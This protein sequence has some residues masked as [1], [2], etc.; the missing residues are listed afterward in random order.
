MKYIDITTNS[1]KIE[2]AAHK[3]LIQHV[4]HVCC[5]YIVF[6]KLDIQ[7]VK[8]RPV[9]ACYTS[10]RGVSNLFGPG[11]YRGRTSDCK[12]KYAEL[13]LCPHL[14]SN[15]SGSHLE[16]SAVS[17]CKRRVPCLVYCSKSNVLEMYISQQETFYLGP[18]TQFRDHS[19]VEMT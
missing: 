7:T 17:D 9:L 5:N 10:G 11:R 3:G 4:V 14:P 1:K 6:Q 19:L 2:V 18:E 15:H 13:L 16:M 8:M 12:Q